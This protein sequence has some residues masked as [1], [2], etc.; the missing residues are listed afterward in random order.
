MSSKK[1]ITD[2]QNTNKSTKNLK[3]KKSTKKDKIPE[4]VIKS[5]M[6]AIN[7]QFQ[8]KNQRKNI[9]LSIINL[10]YEEPNIFFKNHK[11]YLAK[12]SFFDCCDNSIFSHYFYVLYQDYRAKKNQNYDKK[13]ETFYEIYN[14]NFNS[15]F[16]EYKN[17]LIIQDCY[18][19]TA[20]HKLAKLR[21]KNFFFEI[22]KRLLDIKIFNNE[23]LSIKNLAE[24]TCF[25]YIVDDINNNYLSII[26][27]SDYLNYKNFL[28]SF[29][30]LIEKITTTNKKAMIMNFNLG[31]YFDMVKFNEYDFTNLYDK[32]IN[33]INNNIYSFLIDY[34]N[35]GINY[36]NCLFGLCNSSND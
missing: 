30:D 22:C 10:F 3:V 19:D 4:K 18:L 13:S 25:N 33:L 17:N 32:I 9:S 34:F 16:T 23:I 2:S 6:Q 35:C 14:N 26:K 15:F 27:K 24:E 8:K 31:L 1:K 36:L 28:N 5:K 7:I 11:T 29:P 21:D 20:F 12:T